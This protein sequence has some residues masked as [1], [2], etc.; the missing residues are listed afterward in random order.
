[1]LF[2]N[3]LEPLGHQ[4]QITE[5]LFCDVTCKRYQLPESL[6]LSTKTSEVSTICSNHHE[7]HQKMKLRKDVSRIRQSQL[8]LTCTLHTELRLPRTDKM[9]PPC[10]LLFLF[11]YF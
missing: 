2:G 4:P 3:S 8:L 1:M 5:V 9:A 6:F 11:T 7:P 10:D